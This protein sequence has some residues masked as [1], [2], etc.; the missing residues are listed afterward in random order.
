MPTNRKRKKYIYK[1]P[2]Q[3]EMRDFLLYGQYDLEGK[4]GFEVFLAE[5]IPTEVK[6]LWQE[7]Q[8]ELLSKWRHEIKPYG[9]C[10]CNGEIPDK[11]YLKELYEKE[12]NL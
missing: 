5:N 1:Y 7:N 10:L 11:K 2:I 3:S 4:G 9:Y 12:T 8:E 6:A